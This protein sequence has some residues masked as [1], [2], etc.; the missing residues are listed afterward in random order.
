MRDPIPASSRHLAVT[1][2]HNIGLVRSIM[3][4]PAIF[5]HISEDG[6][7]E[8]D[9][10]DHESLYWLLVEDEA[11]AGVFL[12][13]PHSAV[14]FEVHTCLLPR[15]WGGGAEEAARLGQRWMFEN[16]PCKKLVT[17]VPAPN[18]LARRFAKRCG[19]TDEG[20]N[21]ASFLKGGVLVD[22]FSLGLTYEEWQCQQQQ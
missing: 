5:P 19:F 14:C 9:P 12:V 1:R 3:A 10:I 6:C 4:H 18:V 20:V 17:H 11:P 7:L 2:T 21:R 8:P 22:Q 16:T 15:I 13:H